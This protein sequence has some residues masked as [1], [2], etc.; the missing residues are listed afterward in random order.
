MKIEK[1]TQFENHPEYTGRALCVD[2]TPLKKVE[3][4]F[5]PREQFKLVFETECLRQ[6]GSPFLVWSAGFTPSLHEKAALTKFLRQWFGRALSQAEQ[7]EFD[8][9]SLVGRAAVVTIVHNDGRDGQTYANIALIQADKSGKPMTP[10]GKYQRVK[11]RPAKDNDAQYSR[12]EQPANGDGA[13]AESWRGVKVHVGKHAGLDLADLDREAV[14]ALIARWLPEAKAKA[15]PLADDRRL[16]AALEAAKA[17]IAAEDN[18]P[19]DN[20]PY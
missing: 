17:E 5:G 15:K 20:Q 8:T 9:E 3:T 13:S 19:M 11:D 4:K 14:E 7:D 12:A 2:V 6:D 18:I 10:S 16:I 1:K